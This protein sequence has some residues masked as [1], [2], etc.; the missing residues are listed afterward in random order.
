M[1]SQGRKLVEN[2]ELV[3]VVER[4]IGIFEMAYSYPRDTLL[5]TFLSIKSSTLFINVLPVTRLNE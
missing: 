4:V 1:T 2:P 5:D 3:E